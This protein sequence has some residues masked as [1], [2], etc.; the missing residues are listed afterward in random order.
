[1][2]KK[3]INQLINKSSYLFESKLSSIYEPAGITH[4]A[5]YFGKEGNCTKWHIANGE[6]P[7]T[8]LKDCQEIYSYN[9]R[10]SKKVASSD[11]EQQLL[12]QLKVQKQQREKQER[13]SYDDFEP[14]G[15]KI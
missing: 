9:N 4:T 12:E 2:S 3:F 14:L 8:K 7:C 5:Q 13:R 10:S 11:E 6:R 1:M 15:G